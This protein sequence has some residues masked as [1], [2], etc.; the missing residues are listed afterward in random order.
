MPLVATSL[1]RMGV[2]ELVNI[3]EYFNEDL[4][5]SLPGFGFITPKS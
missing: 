3:A 4:R 2:F 5:L 1:P